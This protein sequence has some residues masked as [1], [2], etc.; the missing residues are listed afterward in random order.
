MNDKVSQLNYLKQMLG[1]EVTPTVVD[2]PLPTPDVDMFDSVSR[3]GVYGTS[4]TVLE[5]VNINHFLQK[6]DAFKSINKFEISSY[7]NVVNE[8]LS[9]LNVYNTVNE[10]DKFDFIANVIMEYDIVETPEELTGLGKELFEALIESTK[11]EEPTIEEVCEET[12]AD[13]AEVA[14][15]IELEEADDG[16][17]AMDDKTDSKSLN[18]DQADVTSPKVPKEVKDDVAKRIGELDKLIDEF[19]SQKHFHGQ[20]EP[21]VF[22]AKDSLKLIMDKLNAGDMLSFKEAQIHFQKLMSPI[23][24]LFPPSL[25][26]FLAHGESTDKNLNYKEIPV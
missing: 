18:A 22:N 3:I 25:I 10:N 24:N 21:A 17:I 23:T 11:G 13:L 5:N 7:Y 14:A 9:A 2:Y 15:I 6:L 19:N 1:R 26:H 8:V 12:M 20:V 16:S 4:K